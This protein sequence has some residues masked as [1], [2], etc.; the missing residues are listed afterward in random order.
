[1]L[2]RVLA[3]LSLSVCL[4][5]CALT[6]GRHGVKLAERLGFERSLVPGKGFQHVVYGNRLAVGSSVLHV[7]LEG[8]GSP[9]I[10]E[11]WIA[12]DPGPRELFMLDLM[13]LDST[14]SVYLGRPCYHGLYAQ[15]SCDPAL[16]THARYSRRVVASMAQA[17]EQIMRAHGYQ[18]CVLIGYSGGGTLAMLLAERIANVLA[19]VTIAGNLDPEAWAR[20]HH[21]SPLVGSLNPTRRPPLPDGIYQLH[22]AAENDDIV[23]PEMCK[24]ALSNQS[25]AELRVIPDYDHVCC[26]R[27]L[28][29]SVLS[30]IAQAVEKAPQSGGTAHRS[31]L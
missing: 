12:A 4:A 21:Y 2:T 11:R 10:R 23:P 1:M 14:A 20:H 13:A 16:W 9:W 17:L 5:A 18:H 27:E 26:W 30:D 19:V 6:P 31:P 7:Y 25:G 24:A 8:D 28:W 29:P 22:L 15:A 3:A